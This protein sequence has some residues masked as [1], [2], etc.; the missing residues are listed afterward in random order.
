MRK[1]FRVM[2]LVGALETNSTSDLNDL[3]AEPR[4]P[5]EIPKRKRKISI[6]VADATL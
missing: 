6:L 2:R 1:F 5:E 4:A 3:L